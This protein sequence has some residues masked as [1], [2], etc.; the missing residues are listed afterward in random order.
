M[1]A[2]TTSLPTTTIMQN[3]K[4]RRTAYPAHGCRYIS[5]YSPNDP[6][7]GCAAAIS[8][9]AHIM[10]RAMHA[11]PIKLRITAGPASFTAMALPK[12]RPVPM[13]L[14]RPIMASWAGVRSRWRPASR[15]TIAAGW[16]SLTEDAPAIVGSVIVR[17]PNRNSSGLP[18]LNDGPVND[19]AR[20]SFEAVALLHGPP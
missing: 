10:V 4:V 6:A 13:L 5:A 19:A 17:H 16:G 20:L 2:A 18:D 15:A 14:P 3:Q 1:D 8:A 7:A 9:S 11:A 12:N